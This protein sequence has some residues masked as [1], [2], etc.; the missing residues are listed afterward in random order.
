M[1]E[2]K[3]VY[4]SWWVSVVLDE[5]L[6]YFDLFFNLILEFLTKFTEKHMRNFLWEKEKGEVINSR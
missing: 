2:I 6:C 4:R 1:D 5:T 3:V